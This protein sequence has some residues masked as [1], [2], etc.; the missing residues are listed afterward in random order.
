MRLYEAESQGLPVVCWRCATHYEPDGL[1]LAGELMD[2]LE[3]AFT[4]VAIAVGWTVLLF[5]T[6]G[7]MKLAII[8]HDRKVK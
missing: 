3:G 2:F 8:I 6:W 4:I 7:L 5:G 1:G